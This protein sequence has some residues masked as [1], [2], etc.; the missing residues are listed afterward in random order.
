MKNTARIMVTAAIISLSVSALLFLLPAHAKT[1]PEE[2]DFDETAT[3]ESRTQVKNIGNTRHSPVSLR[4]ANRIS[5]K[6]G[7]ILRFVSDP[8]AID[9]KHD[10]PTG[11]LFVLPLIKESTHL[12]VMTDSGQTHSLVLTPAERLSGQNLEIIESSALNV[13]SQTQQISSGLPLEE[14]VQKIFRNLTTLIKEPSEN[15]NLKQIK[16][17]AFN[18]TSNKYWRAG[19]HLRLEHWTL[20]NRTSTAQNI[21]EAAF[22]TQNI[23]ALAVDKASLASGE[24]ADLL[25]IR[26]ETE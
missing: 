4:Q 7:K 19:N 24:K 6:G 8:Q 15:L 18:A 14:Q 21:E 26:L 20:T 25:I 12:F 5:V 13:A 16:T 22:W 2:F 3:V 17:G 11:S 10:E 1:I 23:V 9:I